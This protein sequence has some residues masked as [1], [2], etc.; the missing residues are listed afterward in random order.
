MP[1]VE[2]P[3]T[4]SYVIQGYDPGSIRINNVIYQHS[5]IV[6][7]NQLITDWPPQQVSELTAQHVIDIL[8]LNPDVVLIGTGAQQRFLNP[9]LFSILMTQHIGFEMMSTAA[10]C[11]TFDLL[12]NEGRKVVAGL[13]IA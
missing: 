3:N 9:E 10:A 5:V 13:L 11:R 1:F 4:S 12:A 6:S 7:P 8:Q 2:N